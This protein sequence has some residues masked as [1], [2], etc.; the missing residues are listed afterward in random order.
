MRR[1]ALWGLLLAAT[2][3]PALAGDKPLVGPVPAWV[4]PAADP[5]IGNLPKSGNVF[6]LFDEQV[7]LDGDLV[8]GYFDTALLITSPEVLNRAGTIAYPWQP[9]HGD[10]TFHRIEILRGDQRIDAL[11]DGSDITVLR[12]EAGLERKM[13]DG[14]LTAVRHLEGL[15]VGDVLRVTLSI[16]QRD[17]VLRG[18]VQDS[19]ILLPQPVQLGFGRARLVWAEGR[20]ITWKTLMPGVVASVQSIENGRKELLVSM[21]VAKLPEMPK[22]YPARFEPLPM[23]MFSSFRD[24]SEVKAVM[25]PLYDP[26]N[27]IAAGSDLA[28]RVDAIAARSSD[29]VRRMA[30]ALQLVQEEVRYQ[31]V[32]LGPGNYVPQTPADTWAK[33][34]GDCKAKTLLLLAILNRLGIQAEPV[35]ANA[36]RG[37][38]VRT[39][40]PSPMAFDHVFVRA[41][42]GGESYWL[43]GTMLG[44]R[45]DDIHDVPNYGTVLPLLSPEGGLLDLP[46]RAHGRPDI[47]VRIAYDFSAG[48]HL[49]AP[50]RLELKYAGPYGASNRVEGGGDVEERLRVFAEKAAKSWVGSD[51]IGKP[52]ARYEPVSAVWTVELDGVGYPDWKFEDGRYQLD[53]AP[54]IRVGFDAARG[55]SIWRDIPAII[56]EPW[57]AHSLL[58]IQLPDEGRGVGLTGPGEG[59]LALPAVAWRRRSS[60][61]GATVRDEITSL[62]TGVEVAPADVSTTNKTIYDAMNKTVRLVLSPDY[63]QRWD[64]AP[65]R[66][67][68][69]AVARMR[70]IFD[71]RIADKPEDAGRIADRAWLETRL[72]NFQAAEV[73]YGRAIGLDP[74]A[75]HYL[76]RAG[77]R[78]R[79]GDHPGALLDAKAAYE[80][81]NGDNDARAWYASELTYAGQVDQ[82]LDLLNSEP[83]VATEDGISDFLQ[84][85]DVYELAGR[86]DEASEFVDTALKKHPR[87]AKLLNARCWLR[88]LRNAE[89]DGALADCNRAI[90][91]SADPASFLDSR[92]MVHYRAGRY[93]AALA[94]YNA[95]LEAAPE[96]SNSLYM[97]GIV[98]MRMGETAKGAERLRAA[99]ALYP[100]LDQYYERFG[101]RP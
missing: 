89:L 44:S 3:A 45:I 99:R 23:I 80:L 30:D 86:W 14:R 62:E 31:L 28:G 48:P 42:V 87:M 70:A 1:V 67:S 101:I 88:G 33:R 38:A 96:F 49:P 85:L 21:P 75:K 66:R 41:A 51:D 24:W 61:S 58:D 81:E 4:R 57:N 56:P 55:R 95:A 27:T 12:R 5:V 32:A 69:A 92:G 34:Y 43:D 40:P 9:D 17:A 54:T 71:E 78:S 100:R 76:E 37:D 60:L 64:D 29:P 74:S 16:T 18:G 93:A 65:R 35:L 79:R 59:A 82:A 91:L 94:D 25:G 13:V 19:L 52:R 2:A 39:M 73:D 50:F 15:Q 7:M 84:R 36:R 22:N 20:D 77:I 26:S 83:D 11:K 97:S 8:T 10:I 53:L 98:L 46:R 90:E 68:S 6:P 72:L 63:P 47:D